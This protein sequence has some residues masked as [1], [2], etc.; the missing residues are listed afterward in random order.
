MA[1]ILKISK[2]ELEQAKKDMIKIVLDCGKDSEYHLP[3]RLVYLKP[4]TKN[5][6]IYD[7]WG[8]LIGNTDI[9]LPKGH[10]FASHRDF[11]T[12]EKHRQKVKEVDKIESQ[13]LCPPAY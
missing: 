12:A 10:I 13:I 11:D 3:Y 6:H 2:K 5:Y 1:N 8:R 9:T 7:K 4:I